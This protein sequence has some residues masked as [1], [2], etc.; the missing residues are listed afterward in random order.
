MATQVT[1]TGGPNKQCAI[2]P[3]D[4]LENIN[5][6][7]RIE[8]LRTRL[9]LFLHRIGYKSCKVEKSTRANYFEKLQGCVIKDIPSLSIGK[10]LVDQLGGRVNV[11]DAKTNAVGELDLSL[12]GFRLTFGGK[13]V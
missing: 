9:T 3:L 8:I 11:V 2:M 13:S 7:D 6:A 5:F 1:E 12:D 10:Y 4:L